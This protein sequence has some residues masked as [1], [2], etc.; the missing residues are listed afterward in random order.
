MKDLPAGYDVEDI[1][2]SVRQGL[3]LND[4]LYALP[5]YGE[6][7]VTYYRTD[8]FKDAGLSM[9]E[10]PTWT[11]LGEFAGKLHQPD[12]EQYGMCLRGKAGWGKTSRCCRPWPMPL[13]RVGL[14]K[15]GNRNSAVPNGPPPRISTSIR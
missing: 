6:S 9:P 10:H 2:P 1:F 7:T 3:S 5:F 13:A 14:T 11:Q 15:N 4:T 12:K 8:L